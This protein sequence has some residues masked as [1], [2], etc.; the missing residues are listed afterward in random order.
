MNKKHRD[1]KTKLDIT[2]YAIKQMTLANLLTCLRVVSINNT[3]R[4]L[5]SQI[6]QSLEYFRQIIVHQR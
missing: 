6:R 3:K 1:V 5:V 2:F 4:L